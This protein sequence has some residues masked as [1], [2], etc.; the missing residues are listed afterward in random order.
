M[1]VSYHYTI[2]SNSLVHYA[3]KM[4]YVTDGEERLKTQQTSNLQAY[5]LSSIP[6]ITCNTY[7]DKCILLIRL[8]RLIKHKRLRPQTIF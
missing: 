3:E 1:L 4:H 6:G 8:K 2:E 7:E 5:I